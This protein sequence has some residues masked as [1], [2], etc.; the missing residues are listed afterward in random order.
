MKIFGR[1]KSGRPARQRA[2]H[3]CLIV[4]LVLSFLF[5]DVGYAYIPLPGGGGGTNS[6][7]SYT[8]LD[9]WPF[10][11][12]TNWTSGFGYAPDS[13]TNISAAWLGDGTSAFIDS[14]NPSWLQYNV[15]EN[16]GTTNLTVDQGSVTFWFAPNWSSTNDAGGGLGP[17]E[18][19]RLLEVGGYAYDGARLWKRIDQ[20]P[21]NIQVWIGNIYEEKGGKVL[22]HVFAG[23]EQVCT[24]ETNSVLA[25]GTDTNRVSDYYHEDS[26]N[27]SS[28]LS[29]SSGSQIEVNVYYPFGRTQTAS[30]QAG[31]QVSR[32]FTGQVFDAESGLYYYNA[33]YYD[34]ELGRFIQPDTAIPDLSNPQ[35]YNRYSY[36]V[37]DPLRFTDPTGHSFWSNFNPSLLWDSE[38]YQGIGYAIMGNTSVHQDPNSYQS[39]MA[40]N[41]T[42]LLT[43]LADANG[44]KLGNPATAI[45]K[46]VVTAPFNAAMI[47]GGGQ[48]EKSLL[49]AADK[50]IEYE[51]A[52]LASQTGTKLTEG[53]FTKAGTGAFHLAEKQAVSGILKDGKVI[54]IGDANL[55]HSELAKQLGIELSNGKL[56]AGMEGFLVRK[57]GGKLDIAGAGINAPGNPY[58]VI[59]EAGKKT[60]ETFFK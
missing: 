39:L 44:N 48:E 32:R 25:G 10:T 49:S 58:L 31:F 17:Q 16:D 1:M 22:F 2:R 18:W 11:D 46:I 21:T 57:A 20:N 4:F 19:G 60:V 7:P 29:G 13:F 27:T 51:K 6:S 36:C 30:P 24:F 59:S 56:P 54:G 41:G 52:A 53:W 35:S 50:A 14:P 42:P 23:G 55:G 38:V 12:T 8:P 33:R 43:G 9:Y 47:I 15:F 28:A 37:N 5:A 3:I 34:P 40:N 26:L 45:G